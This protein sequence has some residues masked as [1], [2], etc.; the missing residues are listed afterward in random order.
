[1]EA[2]SKQPWQVLEK[3]KRSKLSPDVPQV[4][5]PFQIKTQNR[6]EQLIQPEVEDTLTNNI[7]KTVTNSENITIN[8][9]PP[10]ILI[11]GVTNYS[12][13][14]EY[15]TTAAKEEQYY[16][17]EWYNKSQ[18][19]HIRFISK[20]NQTAP[21]RKHRVPHLPTQRRKCLQGGH[22]KSPPLNYNRNHK[23]GNSE[24]RPYST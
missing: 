18:Y 5:T 23:R 9:K 14:V 21:T 6:Y 24:T 20:I 11:Y 2:T 17:N 13:M 7:N 1:M 4:S 12:Q 19:E 22:S 8:R 10:P 15:L 3:R 16:N